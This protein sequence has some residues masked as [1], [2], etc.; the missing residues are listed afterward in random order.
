MGK[1][2]IRTLGFQVTATRFQ[3]LLGPQAPWSSPIYAR[4]CLEIWQHFKRAGEN[5]VFILSF[6]LALWLDSGCASGLAAPALLLQSMGKAGAAAGRQL[7][8]CWLRKASLRHVTLGKLSLPSE[9]PGFSL[10]FSFFKKFCSFLKKILG[11]P[12]I[13]GG[14]W[15]R[16]VKCPIC[17][18]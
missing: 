6:A 5:N 10:Y 14:I 12:Q 7:A 3:L 4:W 13:D 8:G 16:W 2:F 15:S 9:G 11:A 18:R 1:L 17:Q